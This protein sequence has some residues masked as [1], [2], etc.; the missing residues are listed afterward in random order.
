[1]KTFIW[2]LDGTLI[3]SYGAILAGILETCEHYNYIC[4]RDEVLKFIKK[5]SCAEFLKLLSKAIDKPLDEILSFYNN[6]FE[7]KNSMINL[8]PEAREILLRV[9]DN[10]GK[11]F[12]ITHR[13]VSTSSIL[14]RLLIGGLF[15][16]V[17]TS[18]A[19]FP[20]KPDPSSVNHLIDKYHLD[21]DETYYVGDRNLDIDF[22]VN[23]NIKTILYLPYDSPVVPSGKETYIVSNL[24]QITKYVK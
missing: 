12:I 23:A 6:D 11:N 4:D 7:S 22:G 3:D 10:G 17:I 2:D 15:T 20:R 8:I 24:L 13:G 18:T 9:I 21:K 5:E 19:G 1:M 14:N 16:E